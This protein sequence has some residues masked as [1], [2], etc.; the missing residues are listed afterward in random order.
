MAAVL[1]IFWKKQEARRKRGG[2]NVGEGGGL[3]FFC[4]VLYRVVFWQEDEDRGGRAH[5]SE[6]GGRG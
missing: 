4:G 2:I 6:R 5:S 3:I 1:E